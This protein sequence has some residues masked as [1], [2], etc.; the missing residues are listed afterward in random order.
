[1]SIPIVT[2]GFF[3]VGVLFIVKALREL[4]KEQGKRRLAGKVWLRTG[5]LFLATAV[6]LF[7]FVRPIP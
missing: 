1:L 2:P 5:L 6:V 7:F 4:L 3:G